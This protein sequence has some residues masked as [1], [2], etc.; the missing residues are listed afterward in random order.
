[1]VV[2]IKKKTH[3]IFQGHKSW[4]CVKDNLDM[5]K[6]YILPTIILDYD[7]V[8]DNGNDYPF[9]I[10]ISWLFW[11]MYIFLNTKRK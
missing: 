6:I 5:Y 9:N 2:K 10:Q 8:Y 7:F 3:I 11:N 1:M 4:K